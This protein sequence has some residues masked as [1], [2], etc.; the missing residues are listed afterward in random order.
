MSEV[1][2]ANT[3]TRS[4]AWPVFWLLAVI[5]FMTILDT[6][7][8]AIA[9]P[10]I[11]QGLGFSPS[12]LIWVMDGYILVFGGLVML[13][14]RAADLV[15]RRRLLILGMGLFTVASAVCAFAP[16]GWL[17]IV[18]RVA[19][20]AGAALASPAALALVIDTFPEG[21]DRNKAMA[22]WGGIGGIAGPVGVLV[23]GLLTT[24]SWELIFLINLPVGVVVLFLVFRMVPAHP[25]HATGGIDLF[26]ALTGTVGL[27]LLIYGSMR[28]SV[29]GWDSP[30]TLVAFAVA[31]VLLIAF[32]VRQAT[33][34]APLLPRVLFGL[35]YVV[36]GTAA[37]GLLGLVLYGVF[38]TNAL[39]LQQARGFG[40]MLAAIVMVP[41]DVSLFL[42]TIVAGRA[43]GKFGP[44]SLLI[45]GLGVQA[46]CLAWWASVLNVQG[47][48]FVTL[49]LP[50]VVA[51][52]GLGIAIVSVFVVATSGTTG[53]TAGAA[54]GMLV[55]FNQ[56]GG[57]IGI[58]LLTT[59]ATVH[60]SDLV[61]A[62]AVDYPAALTSGHSWAFGTA[63]VAAAAA[64]LIGLWLKRYRNPAAGWSGRQGTPEPT[65]T[66]TSSQ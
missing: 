39:H 13:G 30:G 17:L 16:V 9:L 2:V 56:V 57:A 50:A 58:A 27:S 4:A 20:G 3:G 22:L 51:S 64:A 43:M 14:G 61:S 12:G 53:A 41:L 37:M 26:G 10:S 19:Q 11:Q 24:A 66:T 18:G 38:V 8:V 60:A 40:P 6:A 36:L 1:K 29:D 33:A 59:I 15:G 48:I 54:S 23:G 34:K 21:P 55:T 32:V 65:A 47:N 28:A 49:I 46:V 31:V 44:V 35:P 42:G 63:A 52:F 5:Q 25:P 62:G 45:A 7:I